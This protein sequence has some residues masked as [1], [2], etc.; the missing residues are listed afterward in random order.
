M[1]RHLG[2]PL[3]VLW[4]AAQGLALLP[5]RADTSTASSATF[6]VDL[7]S[8]AGGLAVNGRVR[9]AQGGAAIS[10][11]AVSLAGQ[12]TTTAGD[13]TFAL[14]GVVLASGNTLT[15]S[16]A[17]YVTRTETASVPA[18]TKSITLPDILLQTASGSLPVVTALKPKYEGIF[19]S[20]ASLM[21]DYTASVNWNGRTA[22]RVEFYVNGAL[23]KTVSTSGTEATAALDM[24]LGFSGSLTLG[25]NKV[26]VVAVDSLGAESAP[27]EQPVTIIPMPLFLVD[28]GMML[29]FELIEWPFENQPAISWEFNFPRSLLSARDVQQIP[30]IGNF[31]PDFNFDVA[32]DYE[33]LS[34]EW[35][36]FVGK[37]W[38]KR[39]H[40]RSGVRPHSAPLHP[41][42][43]FGNVDFN[44]GF[45]GKAEGVASQTRGI[46][47]ERVGVQLSAGIR[48]E[49][50]SFYFTDYVPGGQIVRLLDS[51]KH[52]GVD[53]N[54]IQRVRVDGLLDAKLSAMLEFPSLAFDNATLHVEPGVEAV[55]EPSL[56]VAHGSI[57]VGGN[58]GFDLQLAPRFGMEEITG[59]VYMSL[60]FDAWLMKPYDET[61]I[62][63]SGTIY[64]RPQGSSALL[65][66][67]A[68][69]VKPLLGSG[70]WVVYHVAGDACPTLRRDYLAAGPEQFVAAESMRKSAFASGASALDSFRLLSRQPIQGSVMADPAAPAKAESP[71]Y[72]SE[73]KGAK[74]AANQA[75]L[76]LVQN[77]FPASSPA[78]AARGTEL[79]L[80][81]VADNGASHALQFTDIRWTRWDGTNWSVAATIHTNTQAEFNPQ[82]AY[83]G[84]GDA[85][86]VWERVAD[87]SFNETNLTA[88]AAQMEIV[89]SKW[90]R[91][92][93]KWSTPAA[94]TANGYLDH[95]PLVCGP[96]TNGAVFATWTANT[97]NL[98]MGTNA[99]G[100]QVLWA[101]WSPTSQSWSAPQMLLADLPNR[102]SQSL[103]GVSNRAVYAWTRDLDGV[104]TNAADQQ[105]F[106]CQWTGAGWGAATQFTTNSS[107]NR[108]ARVAVS[109]SIGTA[110]TEGFE[111]GGFSAQPWTFTGS[112][113]WTVQTGTVRSG[114]YA[115]ASGTISDSQSSGMSL[116]L[117]CQ[118]G[119]VSFAYSVSSE[120]SYDYLRFYLDG[121]QQGAWSGSVAWQTASYPVAAGL[122]TFEW[123]YTK[124]GSVSSGSDRAWVDDISLPVTGSQPAFIVWQQGTNLLLS[125]DFAAS[126][127]PAR[128][129]SQ[130][131]GFA[132]YALTLGPLGHLVLLWQEMSQN[133]SDAH[134]AVYDPA[135][136]TWSK[137]DLLCADPP[138]ER[139]FAPVW[140]NVGNLTVAYNKVEVLH[141]NK[142]VELESGGT[143]T[144]TNVPEPGRVDLLVTKRALVKDLALMAG[145]FNVQGNNYLP[146]DP[147]TLSAAVRNSG[148]VA[149][150]NVVVGF[151]DGNPDA[152]G[153]LVTNVTL[154][155][156]LL[157]AATNVASALWVVPEPATNRVLYAVVNRD[158]LG[159]EFDGSNNVQVVSIGG[160]DL[161]V[162]LVS[163][164][165]ETNGAM[166]VI[167]QVQNLGAP[168]ATNSVLAI[169]RKGEAN[170]PLATAEVP[171]LEPGRLAQVA[172]DLPA[173][174]QPSG[175][176]LYTLRADDGGAVSDVDTNNNTTS[177][178]AYLW[179]DSDSDGIPDDWMMQY[180]GHPTGLASDNSRAEDSAAGDGISNLQKYLS[181]RSPLVWNN[182]HFVGCQHLVDG[183]LRLTVFGQVGHNYTLLASTNLA[184]WA[185]ILSFAC[186]NSP[187]DVFDPD[188]NSF[189]ARFYRLAP[190]GTAPDL[191]LGLGSAQPLSS[192]GLDLVLYGQAGSS[193]R[194]D[195]SSNLLDWTAVT[196]FVST[197]TAMYF[198]DASATN[199]SRRFYRAVVP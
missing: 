120:S 44:W 139:S 102:L 11:A 193:Y 118:A 111:S 100:S 122:H 105:V 99:A 95:A 13:G 50:L 128:A 106:Y 192:S 23:S 165:A 37:E 156:W 147:L 131:A 174:T 188:A 45:G 74:S 146:G 48:A 190:P 41:K 178:A 103:A 166:R 119:S 55:Y 154:P 4:C 38:D 97:S 133:G 164:Q 67:G 176:A 49:I 163:Y 42:F 22:S 30:F 68:K 170:A 26:K 27:F 66:A 153:V 21:N 107:G 189:S 136:D 124:D 187:M 108:N 75:D 127:A 88:M 9:A 179:I 140:D 155:G 73:S 115:A 117:N 17:G 3:L 6:T 109:T 54:S 94:L 7:Q 150:S 52:V 143:I 123:R 129:D 151:Y 191:R 62:I 5:A 130:T 148:N 19:L 25:A 145:D 47:I 138:L 196:N 186:T 87:P 180:F 69:A 93:G 46:V 79:M 168:N 34:G 182:L 185:P 83:D 112:A 113:P 58:L 177:F 84:N 20:G 160:S 78:M 197:N 162:G 72:G 169:R 125:R 28:Q 82:V 57:A 56:V 98:L 198:R 8:L 10:G 24:A 144:V 141:T 36:L 59:A 16:K 175:E 70:A 14:S 172:L 199:Y 181:G 29:P 80:L 121:V 65:G 32:F 35:G 15:V 142:T 61:F 126:A 161:A 184:A 39:L 114:S 135:S 63:L 18:G 152:G 157:A 96:M 116:S 86:A 92:S 167:A 91:A 183:R 137:D 1:P 90:S 64:Q 40:Y 43:Y 85:I 132:D 53:V 195:A 81:Y 101:E 76:T 12:N 194:I 31:G 89:W 173:G 51:L 134:Y 104:L 2:L 158:G 71:T 171:L 159:S 110:S 33:L 60:Y 77:A 149:M